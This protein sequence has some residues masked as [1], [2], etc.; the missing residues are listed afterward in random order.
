VENR[1]CDIPNLVLPSWESVTTRE[2]E[3][4]K[5]AS[6]I[7]DTAGKTPEQSKQELNNL[8]LKK[9]ISGLA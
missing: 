5:S 2:Y 3:L 7:L 6:I 9:D 1:Q 4:W 8:L